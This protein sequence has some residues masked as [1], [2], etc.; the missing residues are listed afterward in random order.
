LDALL[1]QTLFDDE[2]V[3]VPHRIYPV[4]L[5]EDANI[6]EASPKAQRLMSITGKKVLYDVPDLREKG[7]CHN[8]ATWN[9]IPRADAEIEIFRQHNSHAQ[10]AGFCNPF[11]LT[12]SNSSIEQMA[13]VQST[14][15]YFS[16]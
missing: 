15:F 6:T 9:N 14:S 12:S 4:V 16:K 10:A 11:K 8:P 1:R 2:T 7:C 5:P 3:V 13:P